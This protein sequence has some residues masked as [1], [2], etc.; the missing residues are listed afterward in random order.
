[1]VERKAYPTVCSIA[2]A[3]R[4]YIGGIFSLPAAS[5]LN[6][7][8]RGVATAKGRRRSPAVIEEFSLTT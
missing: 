6:P 5:E 8:P 1:M 3:S 2:P 7:E 4:I